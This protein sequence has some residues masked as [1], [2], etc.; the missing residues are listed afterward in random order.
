ME[1]NHLSAGPARAARVVALVVL[2]TAVVFVA[3]LG[4][5]SPD[6]AYGCNKRPPC[7]NAITI[8]CPL[9]GSSITIS[10]NFQ[11]PESAK[12]GSEKFTLKDSNGQAHGDGNPACAGVTQT[13][14]VQRTDG[15]VAG[16]DKVHVDVEEDNTTG[17]DPGGEEEDLLAELGWTNEADVKVTKELEIGGRKIEKGSTVGVDQKLTFVIK[18]KN[19]GPGVADAFSITDFL[20]S[21]TDPCRLFVTSVVQR[22]KSGV[23]PEKIDIDP[24]DS[25]SV[26]Y[27]V[28]PA[29][30]ERTI[31]ITARVTRVGNCENAATYDPTIDSHFE[32]TDGLNQDPRFDFEVAPVPDSKVASAAKGGATGTAS[33][34]PTTAARLTE[35]LQATASTVGLAKVKVA[36]LRLSSSVKG[37][38]G[39]LPFRT[40]QVGTACK[41]LKSAD[42]TFAGRSAHRGIC[43]TPVWL[44]ATGT[45]NW[46]YTLTHKLPPGSYVVYSRAYDTTGRSETNFTGADKNRLA[47]H[48]G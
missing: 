13:T 30:V 44:K 32:D 24:T 47:F 15:T 37:F 2:A 28:L 10:F 38:R 19:N 36:I 18:V 23:Q 1:H 40:A 9:T 6:Q 34:P 12:S 20:P 5:H 25:V 45:R 4:F 14:T 26:D 42:A 48:V 17:S 11:I 33:K 43:D 27:D 22:E 8:T 31:V 39:Q 7:T 35:S 16:E 46:H 41:W 3:L 21:G 29:G